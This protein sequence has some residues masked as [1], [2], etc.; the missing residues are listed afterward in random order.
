MRLNQIAPCQDVQRSLLKISLRSPQ[1]E[2]ARQSLFRDHPCGGSTLADVEVGQF[3]GQRLKF[4]NVCCRIDQSLERL[5]FELLVEVELHG[6]AVCCA[7]LKKMSRPVE[8][9]RS[10]LRFSLAR[11]RPAPTPECNEFLT[12]AHDPWRAVPRKP[13]DRRDYGR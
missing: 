11:A 12:T 7:K 3:T 10:G 6:T 9:H 13:V 4:L 1:T 8:G 5:C 2:H